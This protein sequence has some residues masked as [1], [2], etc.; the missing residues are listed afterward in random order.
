MKDFSIILA[1]LLFVSIISLVLVSCDELFNDDDEPNNVLEEVS[2]IVGSDG[3]EIELQSGVKVVIPE[4]A[5][6]KE[7]QVTIGTVDPKLIFENNEDDIVVVQCESESNKFNKDI[8]ILIPFPDN[9]EQQ[10]AE[11]CMGGI[12]DE[13]LNAIEALP[14]DVVTIDEKIYLR[15]KTNHFTEYTGWFWEYPPNQAGPWEVPYYNQ[16][17]S[18]YCWATCIQMA[19]QGVKRT[20]YTI[21]EVIGAC[22]YDEGGVTQYG[23]RASSAVSSQI[24]K[25]T[26]LSPTR[27]LF[28]KG[29]ANAMDTKI[30]HHVALGRSVLVF[31]PRQEHAF[32]V[33]GY[34]GNTFVIHDPQSTNTSA[35]GY[36]NK[37]WSSF[38]VDKMES[39]SEKFVLLAVP[40]KVSA[41]NLASVNMVNSCIKIF[42]PKTNDHNSNIFTYKWD[43]Q[44]AKGYSFKEN[45]GTGKGFDTIPF[46]CDKITL[47]EIEIAN[48]SRTQSEF[49]TVS[50]RVQGIN[51]KKKHYYKSLP[52]GYDVGPNSIKTFKHEIDINEFRDSSASPS[53]FYLTVEIYGTN[54]SKD[55]QTVEFWMA[56]SD[57]LNGTWDLDYDM[58]STTHPDGKTMMS[59][60]RMTFQVISDKVL[61]VSNED[62]NVEDVDY[63]MER[64][65]GNKSFK[66]T[67]EYGGF[68]DM[69]INGTLDNT[70]N[71][72]TGTVVLNSVYTDMSG[73]T[74]ELKPFTEKDNITA[75]RVK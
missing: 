43:Y 54:G 40:A 11:N 36:T 56:P 25:R 24:K 48:A 17:S 39:L 74:P 7:E 5:L 30:R 46:D 73:E 15:I 6:G 50:V 10:T 67:Y 51:N 19:C 41:S 16:G 58:I 14:H 37:S 12:V 64:S 69:E 52:G 26:G 59:D 33:V 22:K 75:T 18:T 45:N 44:R 1:R 4:G 27:E 57:P 68:A 65:N 47:Q 35:V 3:G 72:W 21:P 60:V 55:E 8:E 38:D 49:F 9:Y 29:S 28:P 53:H 34:S 63:K 13:E 61:R 66:I 71:S 32:L 23:L 62:P 2:E 20:D 42:Q 31:S 70:G